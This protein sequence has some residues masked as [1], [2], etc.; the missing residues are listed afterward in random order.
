MRSNAAVGSLLSTNMLLCMQDET[1]VHGYSKIPVRRSQQPAVPDSTYR[2][3]SALYAH[4]RRHRQTTARILTTHVTATSPA[5]LL[6]PL[7]AVIGRYRHTEPAFTGHV[8]LM[9]IWQFTGS[10]YASEQALDW[11]LPGHPGILRP[12]LTR[13]WVWDGTKP[14]LRKS[15][16]FLS[17]NKLTYSSVF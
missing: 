4:T 14:L 8:N 12:N 3:H 13:K 11:L 2:Q 6:N 1:V 9:K 10:R 7:A 5:D 15:F 16:D 17:G